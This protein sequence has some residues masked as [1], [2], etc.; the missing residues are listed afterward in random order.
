MAD[1]QVSKLHGILSV[2][3][4][5]IERVYVARVLRHTKGNKRA[6]ARILK[7]DRRTLDRMIKRHQ[8][9]LLEIQTAP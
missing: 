6:A 5:D 8:L 2:L 7:V 9:N 3:L 1:E 4:E